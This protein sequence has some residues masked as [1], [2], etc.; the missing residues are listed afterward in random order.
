MTTNLEKPKKQISVISAEYRVFWQPLFDAL[1]LNNAKFGAKLCYMGLE[2]SNDGSRVPCIRFFPSE[3][4]CGVDY[5]LELFDWNQNYYDPENRKLYKLA[6]N[7]N[8]HLEPKKYVEIPA[9][10][11]P[12]ATFA[13]KLSDLEL[14]NSTD[15]RSLCLNFHRPNINLTANSV[16]TSLLDATNLFSEDVPGNNDTD[17]SDLFKMEEELSEVFADKDDNHYSS[18]TI[19]DLYCML[20]NV[21]MSNKK[22]LNQLISKGKQ[23]QQQK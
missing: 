19:R 12:T 10:K 18:M 2:F 4:N 14:V 9:D 15:A 17:T 16:D 20:Q 7:P 1:G 6:Y 11:L 22:W 5:Y 3:L 8:W 21:P 23:W 13:V